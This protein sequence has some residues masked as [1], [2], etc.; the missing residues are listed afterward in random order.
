[1]KKITVLCSFILLLL[2]QACSQNPVAPTE[3]N[4]SGNIQLKIDRQNAPADVQIVTA[5]L[6]RQGFNPITGSMNLL[7]DST[8]D[9]NLN[10]IP[11]G[12]WHLKI[13]AKNQ[14][15]VIVYTGET[16]V[17]ILESVTIQVSL[18]LIPVTNGTGNIHIYVTW[19]SNSNLN[20]I[21]YHVNPIITRY[22]STGNPVYV[23]QGKVLF[24][25]GKY[26]MWYLNG[27]NS[28]VADI[29]YAESLDGLSWTFPVNNP[30][31]VPGTYY[32]DYHAV[33]AGGIL[34]DAQ[35]YKF[36]FTGVASNSGVWCIGMA[37]SEDG[38]N[39][40]KIPQPIILPDGNTNQIG[41]S[42]VILKDGVYYLFYSTK[43][44][45]TINVATSPDGYNWTKY[46]GNPVMTASQLWEAGGVAYGTVIFEDNLFKMVYQNDVYTA[47]GEAV[48]A[49]GF[50]WEK[51]NSNPFFT[52]ANVSNNWCTKIAYPYYRKFNNTYMLYYSGEYTEGYEYGIT[53]IGLA[54][55]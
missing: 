36:Y 15:G 55:K 27:Y 33:V 49:D 14:N 28:G 35:G 45:R 18:T 48:S 34:K 10:N 11:V 17:N 44:P 47:F 52:V 30:V 25:Q 9:L 54:R 23:S 24:D 16:D 38:I 20:W 21:D 5:K 42:D 40:T 50:T 6:T 37:T 2:L 4:Q 22:S 43:N 13:D 53:K 29:R 7:S 51:K 26:K 39:W 41:V 19:G 1:M 3:T 46:S 32:W 31:L 12:Q 8:A